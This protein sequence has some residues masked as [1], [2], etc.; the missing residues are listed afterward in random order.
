[1]DPSPYQ[2]DAS[3]I[4]RAPWA[5]AVV[6][7]I[8]FVR[9]VA[10]QATDTTTGRLKNL[11]LEQLMSIEV[12][13]VSKRPE[14]LSETA[15]AIQV[16]T[17]EDI[18]RSGA[19]NLAE[20]LRLVPNLQVAQV[21]ASQYAISA[22]GFNNVLANKLLVLIDGRTV[23]TPLYAGVF[24]DVQN[25]PLI[26]IDR[27]E[28][29]SG[30]GGALWGANAV[31]GVINIIT[32]KAGE[33]QGLAA[34]AAAGTEWL[35]DGMARYGGS[36]SRAFKGRVY[37]EG[38]KRGS[39]FR[40]DS[41]D[42]HDEWHMYQGGFRIDGTPS[43]RTD[44]TVQ[45]DLY[46]GRPNPD[47]ATPVTAAG[48]NLLTRWSHQLSGRSDFQLQVYYDRSYRDFNN[49]FTED[50]KTY[51]FDWQHR[52]ELGSRQEIIWGLNVR[53]MDHRTDNLELFA[54][55]P[56]SKLLHLYSGF[57]QDEITLARDRLR[58]TL[59]VKPEHNDYTGWEVQPSGRLAWTPDSRQTIWAAVSRA[60]RTPARIDRDFT[61]SIAPGVPFIIGGNLQSEEMVAWELGWRLQ[62]GRLA[63]LSVS[64]FY[65]DYDDI[66]SAEPGP[67]PL[68]IPVTFANGVA[69]H[70]EGVEIAS[71]LQ[72]TSTW[73]LRAG[74]TFLSRELHR[75]PGSADL[76]NATA[77]SDDPKHQFL[78]ESNLDLGRHVA[79]DAVLRYVDA[80]PSPFVPSYF[81]LDLR[82]AV[83]LA[84]RLELSVAGQNLLQHRHREFIPSAATASI[85]RGA[86]VKVTWH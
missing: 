48:G 46:Y 36:L 19:T 11:T 45:S 67:P 75:K 23:Y 2:T 71:T 38:F 74:Y 64:T 18:R 39:T 50:L 37:A 33:T 63:S 24:W 51:D 21:N 86:Y 82:L 8:L 32:R 83:R 27:I 40:G 30:P 60:V 9:P 28:V 43:S 31:N 6:A 44:L 42:A 34:E 29:I 47:G 5:L 20:A 69:G 85:E 53:L 14:R 26:D 55:L 54:F 41:I 12:T 52:F 65:N 68:G 78:V 62:A 76:N 58:L 79:W 17:A 13:S 61:L 73:R 49:G 80:L 72:P 25:P 70:S 4:G 35:A 10:G 7:T 84:P 3:R 15:S 59:G 22:R 1:M 77:E 66:R 16:I 81:G 56:E 57:V